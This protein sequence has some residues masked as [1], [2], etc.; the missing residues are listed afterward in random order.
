MT[1]VWFL[2][3]PHALHRHIVYLICPLAHVSVYFPTTFCLS[4]I[5]HSS[6]ESPGPEEQHSFMG[7]LVFLWER[8]KR[9]AQLGRPERD[10]KSC[11]LVASVQGQPPCFN[12]FWPNCAQFH[13][14]IFT[15]ASL[16]NDHGLTWKP[17]GGITLSAESRTGDH[18][19]P[20]KLQAERTRACFLKSRLPPVRAF[21]RSKFAERLDN[22]T[23]PDS[24]C[25]HRFV[26]NE[27]KIDCS[28]LVMFVF[29]PIIVSEQ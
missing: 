1:I 18:L 14:K 22:N 28:L 27:P 10:W 7:T 9:S 24:Y 4:G 23:Y 19:W 6:R 8:Y 15:K 2:F 12:P 16:R 25:P 11:Q 26:W 21:Y 3:V 29:I 5:K 20:S 17:S 13:Q